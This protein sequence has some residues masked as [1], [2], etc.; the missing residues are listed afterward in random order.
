ML[1]GVMNT[2]FSFALFTFLVSLLPGRLYLLATTLTY[3]IGIPV[4]FLS[5]NFIVFRTPLRIL[6]FMKFLVVYGLQLPVNILFLEVA[7][8]E[9]GSSPILAQALFLGAFAV[10]AF[11]MGTVIIFREKR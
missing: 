5:Q 10:V 1:V 8:T 4:S 7:V 6:A 9:F 2:A 3:L 11:V